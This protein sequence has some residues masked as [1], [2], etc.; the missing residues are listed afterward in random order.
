[1]HAELHRRAA[2]GE[3]DD[4]RLIDVAGLRVRFENAVL[5]LAH[6]FNDNAV[7]E[8]RPE[9]RRVVGELLRELLTENALEARIILD[10]L[11]VQQLTAGE[12][13][14]QHR[15]LQHRATGI[16]RGAHPGRTRANDD[17]VEMVSRG[18]LRWCG[19]VLVRWRV[20]AVVRSLY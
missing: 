9:L 16:H 1:G 2:G 12:A 17:D 11:G 19:G 20:S 13:T 15:C 5:T 18:Q 3:D 4:G 8:I 7:S 10:E 6:A 14:L